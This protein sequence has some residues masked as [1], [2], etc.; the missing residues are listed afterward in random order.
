MKVKIEM[1]VE[2][3]KEFFDKAGFHKA[4]VGLSGGVDHR[5]FRRVGW[6]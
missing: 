1:L 3:L 2:G 6:A 5:V 4:V